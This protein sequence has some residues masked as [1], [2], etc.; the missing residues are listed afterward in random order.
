MATITG[1]LTG[2]HRLA[3]ALFD[4]AQE[5]G[6]RGD[7]LACRETIARFRAALESHM[8]V[9]EQVLFPAFEQA[10]GMASGP[11]A[12]M[13][14][15]HQQMLQQLDAI[16]AAASSG[17]GASFASAAGN[18]KAALDLHSRKEEQIL[19]PMCDRVADANL[20]DE[21]E[22]TLERIRTGT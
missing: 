5:S 21:V 10:T 4:A 13:R 18:F 19:Y 14:I 20:A 6:R 9:E 17:D 3:D 2:D 16:A 1:Y 15:E 11:T 22:R 8:Q 12:V 7:W